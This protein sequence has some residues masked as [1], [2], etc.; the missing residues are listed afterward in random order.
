MLV[1]DSQTSSVTALVYSSEGTLLA[2]GGRD[3]QVMIH[4]WDGRSILVQ[5]PQYHAAIAALAFH[6]QNLTLAVGGENGWSLYRTSE[7]DIWRPFGPMMPIPTSDLAFLDRSTLVVGLGDRLEPRPGQLELWD[8]P[9]GRK[10]EPSHIASLGLRAIAVAPRKSMVAWSAPVRF[11]NLWDVRRQD[12]ITVT[13]GSGPIM[14]IALHPTAALLAVACDWL[15][16][17]YDLNGT[18]NLSNLPEKHALKGHKGQVL[19]VQF[20]PDGETLATASRDRTVRIWDV[21]SGQLI[22]WW[23]GNMGGV[24]SLAFSPDGTRLAAG[25]DAGTIVVWDMD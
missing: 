16:R 1:Y 14:D 15:V 17:V 13:V 10:I 7:G 18:R 22:R 21:A 12:P 5:K 4:S 3:G 20:S 2:S 6:P 8:F 11:V 19:C 24:T 25:G 23:D 9:R